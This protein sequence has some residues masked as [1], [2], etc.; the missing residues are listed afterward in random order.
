MKT[1]NSTI[2]L[3]DINKNGFFKG[4]ASVF[5]VIDAHKEAILPGAFSRTLHIWKKR[6][7]MPKML[8]QHDTNQP[9]GI[10]HHIEENEKGLLVTGQTLREIPRGEESYHLL[11]SGIIDSLSIGFFSCKS[12]NDPTHKLKYHSQVDLVEISLVT[13][14]ANPQARI[15]HVKDRLAH[16]LYKCE[17]L[18]RML[19]PTPH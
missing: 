14:P 15:L 11:K 8:W 16:C 6:H 4:Y 2:H 18:T 10:W 5:N 13:Y 3:K 19:S 12:F 7:D 1:S 9:I 17:A